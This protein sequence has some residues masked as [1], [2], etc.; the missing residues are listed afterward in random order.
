MSFV[1]MPSLKKV[2]IALD[3]ITFWSK[4]FDLGSK[5][6]APLGLIARL[7]LAL[8]H[9]LP[10]RISCKNRWLCRVFLRL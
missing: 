3:R 8:Q 1:T 6:M 10:R 9:T 7:V 4:T 2:S 5:I